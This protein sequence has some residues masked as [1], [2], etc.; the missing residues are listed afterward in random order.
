MG[1]VAHL[2]ITRRQREAGRDQGGPV[3]YFKGIASVMSFLQP[4]LLKVLHV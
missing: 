1:R 4:L 3:L 2:M